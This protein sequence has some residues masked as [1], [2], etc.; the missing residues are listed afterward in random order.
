LFGC[1]GSDFHR[2]T[3][4][5]TD[6]GIRYYGS[7]PYLLI[8]TDNDGG[9]V[10]QLVY[11]PDKSKKMSVRPYSYLAT[12]ATTLTF[13]KGVLRTGESTVDTAVIPKA[14]LTALETVAVAA[15]KGVALQEE[16]EGKGPSVPFPVLFKIEVDASGFHLY[17]DPNITGTD[18]IFVGADK[19]VPP[20]AK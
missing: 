3:D 17:G 18:G 7:S 19:P 1:A 14:V 15:I 16:S 13:D 6:V 5:A 12:N 8:H 10:S 20:P 9:L 11:L 2:V 4:D